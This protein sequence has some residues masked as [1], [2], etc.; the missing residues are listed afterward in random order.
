MISILSSSNQEFVDNLDDIQNRLNTDELQISSGSRMNQVSDD[1]DQVSE[2]LQARAALSASQQIT[3]NLGGIS[4]EVNT[5]EQ[6]LE[7]AVQL[8]DQVQTLAAEGA[9]ATQTAATRTTIAQQ[10]QGIEQQFVGLADTSFEGRYIFSGDSDQTEPYS[11]DVTQADPVSAYLGT[12][13]TREALN[14]NG[15]KFPIALTAQQIFDSADPATNVF[16]ALN[17]LI[18]ALQSNDQAGVQ[19][20]VDGLAT[21]AQYMNNQLA[22]YG[23]TQDTVASAT[24][25]ASTQ[26][27]ELSSVISTLADA[28]TASAILNMTQAQTDEQAALG[29]YAELSHKTLFDFLA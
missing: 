14:P 24:D 21:V 19:T 2:L 28:D 12:A 7:T 27:T 13:S 6:T 10:L 26:Q 16:G 15:T 17:G 5:G 4:A 9:T 25:Y 8:F 18:T 23:T 1:P 22:F 20:S 29:S 11:Y 3:T